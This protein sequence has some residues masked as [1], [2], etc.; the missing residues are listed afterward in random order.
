[1][2]IPIRVHA[3]LRP[4]LAGEPFL[5]AADHPAAR[6]ACP[7]CDEHLA[8]SGRDPRSVVLVFVGVAPD[9]QKTLGYVNGGAV[10]VHAECAGA[11]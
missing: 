10:I 2:L 11:A 8:C 7:A 3:T 9:N 6:Y 5:L 1:M 4:V